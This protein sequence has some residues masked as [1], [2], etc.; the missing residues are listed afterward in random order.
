MIATNQFL[1]LVR[2][3]INEFSTQEDTFSQE[4]DS[5]LISFA[6]MAAP[7]LVMEVP[8]AYQVTETLTVSKDSA[9][10]FFT[11]P[12][13]KTVVCVPVPDDFCRFVSFKADGWRVP[14]NVLYEQSSPRYPS[15]YSTSPGVGAGTAAPVVFL[16]VNQMG[17]TYKSFL[18]G[19]S[20]PA[21]ADCTLVYVK[22]PQVSDVQIEIDTRLSGAM[23]YYTASLYLQSINDVNGSKGAYD[24]AQNLIVKLNS[25]SIV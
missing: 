17:D 12:D 8:A 13:S 25:T 14:V 15:Q 5:T 21:P 19:H 18:E 6:S 2:A 7:M 23:A 1:K 3:A 16:V 11:R 24:F 20:L 22:T 4:T 9:E 10:N